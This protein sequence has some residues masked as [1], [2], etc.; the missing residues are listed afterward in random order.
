[1]AG[2][3][4]MLGGWQ[5]LGLGKPDE[6]I[7]N[8]TDYEDDT[9][10]PISLYYSSLIFLFAVVLWIWCLISWMGMKFFRHAKGRGS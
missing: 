6:T 1:M 8:Y 9:G 4:S 3:V 10:Y 2:I 5:C 7:M